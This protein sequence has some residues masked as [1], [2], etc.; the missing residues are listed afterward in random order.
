LADLSAP[1]GRNEK[2]KRTRTNIPDHCVEPG[3]G[4][5]PEEKAT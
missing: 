5:I 1:S 3:L 2:V 4:L